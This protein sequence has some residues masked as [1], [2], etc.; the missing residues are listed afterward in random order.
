MMI[1]RRLEP[2]TA[3]ANGDRH[4]LQPHGQFS[5]APFQA[6]TMWD[7]VSPNVGTG[8][9]SNVG[10]VELATAADIR[11]RAKTSLLCNAYKMARYLRFP[12]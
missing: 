3:T 12:I 10:N 9:M 6:D 8:T 4:V 2:R 1:L 11:H 5:R 7:R